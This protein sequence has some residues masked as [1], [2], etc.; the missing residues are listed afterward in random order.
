MAKAR[1]DYSREGVGG[2]ARSVQALD[3]EHLIYDPSF[4]DIDQRQVETAEYMLRTDPVLRSVSEIALSGITGG[5]IIF[6]RPGKELAPDAESF[7]QSKWLTF[8]RNLLLSIWKYGFAPVVLRYDDTYKAFPMVLCIDMVR[9]RIRRSI[10]GETQYVFIQKPSNTA[11]LSFVGE[12]NQN[13]GGDDFFNVSRERVVPGV[14]VF[15]VDAPTPTGG[16]SSIVLLTYPEKMRLDE[17]EAAQMR[18]VA[19]RCNPEIIT[20]NKTAPQDRTYGQ[21]G[22]EEKENVR[23]LL[24]EARARDQGLAHGLMYSHIKGSNPFHS[25]MELRTDN[26]HISTGQPNAAATLNGLPHTSHVRLPVQRELARQVMPEEPHQIQEVRLSR[27]EHLC[28]LFGVPRSFYGQFSAGRSGHNSDANHMW[29]HA[30]RKIKQLVTPILKKLVNTIYKKDV[31]L[32]AVSEANALTNPRMVQQDH[33]EVTL[34]GVPP[35]TEM[36]LWWLD[37]NL[38]QRAWTRYMSIAYSM[39]ESDFNTTPQPPPP[40]IISDPTKP[41]KGVRPAPPSSTEKAPKRQKKQ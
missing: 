31:L 24:A 17:L 2:N 35:I 38:S 14:Y 4:V 40:P 7:Y 11:S 23:A 33:I 27:E 10:L 9:T 26:T 36:R 32:E 34:P 30:Q 39:P 20:M 19:R 8:V 37:G 22:E 6:A 21:F 29:E 41:Q 16:L 28:A 18:A 25:V 1:L 3:N 15:E 12:P 13:T 5:G